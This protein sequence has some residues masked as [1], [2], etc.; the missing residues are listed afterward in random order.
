MHDFALYHYTVCR[1]ATMAN[2]MQWYCNKLNRIKDLID[3]IR[4]DYV[5]IAY[6][7]DIILMANFN[8][9]S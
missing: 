5:V 6:Y 9:K 4:H 7:K 8:D 1:G 2:F 3:S